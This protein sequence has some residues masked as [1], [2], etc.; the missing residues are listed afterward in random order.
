MGGINLQNMDGYDVALL[1]S[2]CF[3]WLSWYEIDPS[4]L[5]WTFL[6]ASWQEGV[7]TIEDVCCSRYRAVLPRKTCW[8]CGI[9]KRDFVWISCIDQTGNTHQFSKMF[10]RQ[11]WDDF[12][13]SL[14]P[15]TWKSTKHEPNF[16]IFWMVRFLSWLL[17]TEWL[18]PPF[19]PPINAIAPHLP[20][21]AP[22]APV[23]APAP[24]WATGVFFFFSGPGP[25]KMFS[26]LVV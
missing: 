24:A 15:K 26:W 25:N 3:V 17:I 7:D 13:T 11:V 21:Q 1:T 20:L 4:R 22:A 16:G 12:D 19:L 23:V 8:N 6:G 18:N 5:V 9:P 2:E 10:L 14:L